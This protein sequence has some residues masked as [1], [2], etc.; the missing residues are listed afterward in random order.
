MNVTG[1]HFN[2]FMVCRRKLWLWAHGITM[3]QESE[4]VHE[5]KLIHENCYPQRSPNCEE[6]ALDG[7]KVDFYNAA[8]H[9]IHEIKKTDKLSHAALWQLKYYLYVFETHGVDDIKGILEFPRQRKT[10]TV[11][12]TSDDRVAIEQA[13]DKI[14]ELC[15]Q[16]ECPQPL[17]KAL[18]KKCSYYEFCYTTETEAS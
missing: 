18:C 2:Y 8:K 13:L 5:G 1:T 7:I 10:Q 14:E 4:L 11:T 15:K 12:L 16:E 9:E 3:E 6:I 17:Y